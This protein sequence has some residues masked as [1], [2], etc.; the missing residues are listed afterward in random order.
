MSKPCKL[1]TYLENSLPN[2]FIIQDKKKQQIQS[3][4]KWSN[5]GR[6]TIEFNTSEYCKHPVLHSTAPSL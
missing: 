1:I 3:E 2:C 4:A 6:L 5:N